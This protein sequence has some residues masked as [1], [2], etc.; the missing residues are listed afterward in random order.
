M[1]RARA[2]PRGTA[3]GAPLAQAATLAVTDAF[4]LLS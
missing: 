1:F 2:V 4:N 3:E